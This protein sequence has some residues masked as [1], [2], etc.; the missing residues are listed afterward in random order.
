MLKIIACLY[1]YKGKCLHI[2][3]FLFCILLPH[4]V[5]LCQKLMRCM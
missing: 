2:D 4:R 3:V 1:K 5:E